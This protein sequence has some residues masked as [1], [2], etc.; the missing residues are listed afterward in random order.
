[1]ATLTPIHRTDVKFYVPVVAAF[2]AFAGLFVGTAQGSGIL[3]IL[4]GA[5][6]GA[7]IAWVLTQLL[8]TTSS[9]E[10]CF[11]PRNPKTL[12]PTNRTGF[13]VFRV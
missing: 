12:E 5:V 11:Q 8:F 1:M 4:I 6:L 13:R 9:W 7:G 3:G 10:P 2:G